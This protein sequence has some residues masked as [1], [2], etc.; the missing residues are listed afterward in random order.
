MSNA[1]RCRSYRRRR[2]DRDMLRD[3]VCDTLREMLPQIIQGVAELF[4]HASRHD[5]DMACRDIKESFL[6]NG[7]PLRKVSPHPSKELPLSLTLPSEK[8]LSNAEK[9][10]EFAKGSNQ[11]ESLRGQPQD[12]GNESA[13]IRVKPAKEAFEAWW[14]LYPE[15]VGK[16][17][18]RKAFLKALAKTSLDQLIAGVERYKATKPIDRPWCNPSTWLNQER[19]LDVP[20]SNGAYS[21]GGELPFGG[22][23]KEPPPIP[24]GGFFPVGRHH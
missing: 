3:M 18:A 15:K 16:G 14:P 9:T 7:S 22:P 11:R 19:W 17:A 23:P 12:H 20:A 6:P 5:A 4:R 1:D 10:L 21:N 13:D 8:P 2:H 24:E